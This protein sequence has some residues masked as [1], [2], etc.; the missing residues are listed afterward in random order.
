MN[1]QPFLSLTP[2]R[3]AQLKRLIFSVLAL[4]ALAFISPAPAASIDSQFH[5]PVLTHASLPRK[6]LV[7]P[8]DSF[9]AFGNFDRYNSENFG[10]I[11]KF[12]P[13]GTRDPSFRMQGLYFHV[14]AAALGPNGQLYVAARE[15]DKLGARTRVLRLNSDGSLDPSFDA[16]SGANGTVYAMAVQ[17]DNKLIVGGIFIEFNGQTRHGIVR[18]KP[19]GSLDPGFAAVTFSGS[20]VTSNIIIQPDNKI[21]FAGSFSQ[22]NNISCYTVARLHDDGTLD[23]GFRPSRSDFFS[24]FSPI[25]A[26]ALQPDGKVLVSGFFTRQFPSFGGRVLR[27]NT[28][29]TMHQF[30][31]GE[32]FGPGFSPMILMKLLPNGDILGAGSRLYRYTT[33][34]TIVPGYNDKVFDARTTVSGLDL[35][36]DG[37]ILVSGIASVN[38]TPVDSFVRF[39]ADGSMP[40]PLGS[41]FQREIFPKKL[42]VRSDGKIWLAEM[43][44]DRV[45]GIAVGGLARLQ[46]DGELDPQNTHLYGRDIALSPDDKILII[47][48]ETGHFRLNADNSVDESFPYGQGASGEFLPAPGGKYIHLYNF[49]A[50]AV[51]YNRVV[52]RLTPEGAGDH[53]FIFGIDFSHDAHEQSAEPPYWLGDNRPLAFYAD[54]SFL[55]RFYDETGNYHLRRFNNEGVLDPAFLGGDLPALTKTVGRQFPVPGGYSLAL[56]A[57]Y[58]TGTPVSDAIILPDGKIL[59]VG[60]FNEYQGFPVAGIVRL[61]ANGAVDATFNAGTGAEWTSTT[62]D[63]THIPRIDAIERLADGKF[64]IAGNFEAYDGTPAP[65]LARLNEDGSFDH[66]FVSPVT[67]SNTFAVP[68]TRI[69]PGYLEDFPVSQLVTEP[70]GSILLSGNYAQTGSDVIRSIFRLTRL[71]ET[72]PLN[73]STR[74]RVETGENVLIG[75]FII[76]G[77]APKKVILR[78]IGPSLTGLNVPDALENPTLELRGTGNVLLASNEDWRQTQETEIQNSGLAPKNN[79]ES[80]IITTLAPGQY[81]AIVAGNGGTTGA[82]LLEIYDLSPASDS[83]LAN[84]STRGLVQTGND[85]MIGGFIL[86]NSSGA[87]RVVVRALGPSLTALGISGALQDPMLE[88]WD[89]NGARLATNDEWKD[90]QQ[91]EIQASG[92][93][94][95]NDKEAAIVANLVAGNYTAIV[96]GKNNT[97]GVALVEVYNVR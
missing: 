81:T 69:W 27:L 7:L 34:G 53:N 21:L 4:S 22:V 39:D 18:L 25:S 85:V 80:A 68:T 20:G 62:A 42:A 59:V 41:P 11:I 89:G 83:E 63:A 13:D 28:D 10:P 46:V 48:G 58:A 5:S 77:N 79:F 71:T 57:I 40:T 64:L 56:N 49:S 26:I 31:G 95:S 35:Q 93:P 88:L 44:M 87:T 37:K 45:D 29:G 55:A 90:T 8:D 50:H 72:A 78:A 32:S 16:V 86:G 12:K 76:T 84:I 66:T 6:V 52:T 19:D 9:F 60:M 96:K 54:G 33:D 38:G 61:A 92:I 30:I 70:D 97:T 1:P 94:P 74:M 36:S 24:N 91:G 51:D 67:L 3:Q 73:I 82:G 17:P 2:R 15:Q 43:G 47:A 23:T 75:G 65:G 14:F